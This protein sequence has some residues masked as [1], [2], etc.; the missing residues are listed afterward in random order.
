M[1]LSLNRLFDRLH[2]HLLRRRQVAQHA[3]RQRPAGVAVGMASEPRAPTKTR[4]KRGKTMGKPEE[5]VGKP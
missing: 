5:N 2:G 1:A 3:L 4:G